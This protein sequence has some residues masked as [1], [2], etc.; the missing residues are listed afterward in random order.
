[1]FQPV[2]FIKSAEKSLEGLI[3]TKPKQGNGIIAMC[4]AGPASQNPA[5]THYQSVEG[6]MDPESIKH[7]L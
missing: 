2:I 1:M 6:A 5:G 3:T 7:K 4:P